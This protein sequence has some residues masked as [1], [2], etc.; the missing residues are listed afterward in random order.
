MDR[1]YNRHICP[2][3]VED[4]ILYVVAAQL[5][6]ELH[7]QICVSAKHQ[8]R[9]QSPTVTQSK[10]GS[11]GPQPDRHGCMQDYIARRKQ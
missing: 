8:V 7:T 4:P 6:R 2:S 9:T 10:V 1:V 3:F 11:S 5:A